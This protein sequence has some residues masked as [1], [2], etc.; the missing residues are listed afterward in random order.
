[1]AERE[2]ISTF[3]GMETMD[4]AGV[5]LIRIFGNREAELFDPFLL[6]DLFGSDEPDQYLA[7]FPWHP[8]RV[9]SQG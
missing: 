4:G 3:G 8:H 1:M 6:L 2:V 7:G 9:Y 5:R